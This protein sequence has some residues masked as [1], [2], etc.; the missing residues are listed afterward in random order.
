LREETARNWQK[1][2]DGLTRDGSMKDALERISAFFAERAKES[3]N[4]GKSRSGRQLLENIGRYKV[5]NDGQTVNEYAREVIQRLHPDFCDSGFYHDPAGAL[6]YF[7]MLDPRGFAENVRIIRG[8]LDSPMT[9]KDAYQY[10]TRTDEKKATM[11]LNMLESLQKL[12]QPDAD[13][14]Q[15]QQILDAAGQTIELLNHEP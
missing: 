5:G 12:G 3:D 2:F 14:E 10:Y 9:I 1:K 4:N 13:S 8:P 15:L 11:I 7:I 6:S